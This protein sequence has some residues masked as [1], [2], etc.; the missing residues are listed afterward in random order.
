[1]DTT[2]L[3]HRLTRIAEGSAPPPQEAP[4]LVRAVVA[5]HR[6]QRRQR[7]GMGAVVLAVAAVVGVVPAVLTGGDVPASPSAPSAGVPGADVLSGPT[8]GSLAG[9]AVFVEAVR[10]LSWTEADDP[11]APTATADP[12]L[13]TR[14]VV[15]AGDVPGG[16]WA[17]VAG[18]EVTGSQGS[19]VL[20]F[21]GPEGAAADQLQPAQ[22]SGGLLPGTPVALTDA[23]TGTLVVVGA[24]GDAIEVSPRQEI[25]ADGSVSRA[26][27]PVDA[28]DGVAVTALSP[29]ATGYD[30]AVRYRV[31][32]GGAEVV[33]SLPPG[34]RAGGY[35]P[36]APSIGWPR[37]SADPSV[38]AALAGTAADVLTR[39]GLSPAEVP[40]AVVWSGD[41]PASGGP[42]TRLSL[43]TATLP[44]GATY[45]EAR[46][47]HEVDG[48][49][50]VGAL[51]GSEVR[52][53]GAPL[54]AQTF[55]VRCDVPGVEDS[56]AAE[57][58]LVVVAPA[59]AVGARVLDGAGRPVSEYGLDGGA[60][61]VPAPPGAATV[62]AL[63]ADGTVVDEQPLM[64]LVDLSRG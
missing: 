7:I 5:R 16:R 63:A 47:T 46:L 3:R 32:R 8:R 41:L 64:G 34:F 10:Q 30:E 54:T 23:G 1:M 13:G 26:W 60:A 21:V 2:E 36:A 11:D 52:A 27:Q 62:Q 38:G 48:R 45:T 33:T 53:A 56:P 29:A 42:S 40:F 55:A 58:S 50:Q 19:A 20:W 15:F 44:S 14:H 43:L 22:L 61:V 25:A 59:A 49:E 35:Q 17:L 28:P 6:A 31:R 37:G 12:P 18:Q 24:P 51:C 9:D 57:S 39:I 4:A